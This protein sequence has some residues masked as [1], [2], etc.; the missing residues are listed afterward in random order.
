[1]ILEFEKPIYD[2]QE[3]I[4]EL[5]KSSEE[6]PQLDFSEEIK[7]LEKKLN[8]LKKEIEESRAREAQLKKDREEGRGKLKSYQEAKA[9]HKE[10]VKEET[11]ILLSISKQAQKAGID[12][13]EKLVEFAVD[14]GI[15][16]TML[17][18]NI[19]KKVLTTN[20]EVYNRLMK[21]LE[22][23]TEDDKEKLDKMFETFKE[24]GLLGWR[25]IAYFACLAD[26]IEPGTAIE[27][28]KKLLLKDPEAVE[29]IMK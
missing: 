24:A 19:A 8:K 7:K 9:I 17:T 15:F 25:E 10:K 26:L 2:L 14:R 5:K 16:K 11:K 22:Q 6:N 1:M 29:K 3:K 21:A 13:F 28:V 23:P 18:E 4:K 20:K 12:N 27:D